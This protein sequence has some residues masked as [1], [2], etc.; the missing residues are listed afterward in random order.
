MFNDPTQPAEEPALSPHDRGSSGACELSVYVTGRHQH[1][2]G[3][4]FLPETVL[5]IKSF[6]APA[7][8]EFVAFGS[9]LF[10]L[11]ADF[12]LDWLGNW[13]WR[14]LSAGYETMGSG[15]AAAAERDQVVEGGFEP[16][17]RV[18]MVMR[19]EAAPGVAAIAEGLAFELEGTK[20][21][22]E[23]RLQEFAIG[24]AA[25]EVA[26]LV[27]LGHIHTGAR[28]VQRRGIAGRVD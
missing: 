20:L 10:S 26:R 22:P 6:D 19:L 2:Y 5:L 9:A 15:V 25:F 24:L 18:T 11:A 12:S 14:L 23:V 1:V 28:H 3:S 4:E 17:G 16:A 8:G 27:G 21:E 7:C 13:R